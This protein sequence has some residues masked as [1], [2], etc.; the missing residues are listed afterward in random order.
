MTLPVL[1]RHNSPNTYTLHI[2]SSDTKTAVGLASLHGSS[3]LVVI[4]VIIICRRRYSPRSSHRHLH[5]RDQRV[6]SLV[7]SYYTRISFDACPTQQRS[8]RILTSY[9]RQLETT[10]ASR[11]ILYDHAQVYLSNRL[12][13]CRL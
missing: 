10:T 9:N 4:I 2:G 7:H 6:A 13:T 5:N 1:N 8:P 12:Y 11:T 3:L